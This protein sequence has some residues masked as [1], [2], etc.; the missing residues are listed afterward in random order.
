MAN[1]KVH[2]LNFHSIFSHIEIVLENTS[3]TPHTYYNINRWV[4]YPSSQWQEIGIDP[5]PDFYIQWASSRFS[6]NIEADPTI[7]TKKWQKYWC[8]TEPD[9]SILSNNCAVA[10][11]WF[12]KEFANIPEPNLSNISWNHLAF[13]ILWPSFIPCPITLPGRIMSNVKFHVEAKTNPNNATQYTQLFL[14]MSLAFAALAFAASLFT[15]VIAST[16]LSGGIAALAIAGSTANMLTSHHSFF[17]TY[18]QIT[19][20]YIS[21]KLKKPDDDMPCML[22]QNASSVTLKS[23]HDL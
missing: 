6:F 17:K 9:A 10:T 14:Y 11:Q 13:G 16:L 19:T 23:A 22:L 5:T 18:H 4:E 3:T 20:K 21:D 1:I 15:L 2:V 12:L 7:I 8:D